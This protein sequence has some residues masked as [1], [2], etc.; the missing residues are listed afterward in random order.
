MS[1]FKNKE[2]TPIKQKGRVVKF[3]RLKAKDNKLPKSKKLKDIYNKIRML[4]SH[5]YPS[6]HIEYG[7]LD[8]EFSNATFKQDQVGADVKIRILKDDK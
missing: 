6:A 1:I 7:N 2:L 3:N 5:L 8:I 4:D